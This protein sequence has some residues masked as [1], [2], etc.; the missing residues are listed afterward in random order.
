MTPLSRSG[1]PITSKVAGD[2]IEE[3]EGLVLR[4]G[5]HRARMLEAYGCGREMADFEAAN[6]C[7]LNLP[8]CC[9]WHRAGDLLAAGLLD[10]TGMV[11][12]C[13]D[14]G[15]DRRVMVISDAGRSALAELRTQYP[16]E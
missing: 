7:G 10:D 15:K 13:P 2:E 16:K 8:G 11:T 4:P 6:I 14:T 9:Y 5:T 3:R 12:E 1:D